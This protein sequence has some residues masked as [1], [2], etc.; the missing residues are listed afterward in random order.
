MLWLARVQSGDAAGASAE[1]EQLARSGRLRGERFAAGAKFLSGETGEAEFLAA[2]A[3]L[4]GD[5]K[6]LEAEASFLAGARRLIRTDAAAGEALLRRALGTG[7]DGSYAYDR[8]RAALAQR[9]PGFHARWIDDERGGLAIAAVVPG[10]PAE[11]AGVPSGSIVSS[12]NGGPSSQRALLG[13]LA[14]AERGGTLEM[15]LVDPAGSRGK[16]GVRITLGSSAPTR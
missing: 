15:I 10:G 6:E 16:V 3:G 5:T 13:L 1:L 8:A 2:L 12:M 14:K 7:A 4:D 9:L 11:A